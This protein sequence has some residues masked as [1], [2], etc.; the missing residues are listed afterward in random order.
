MAEAARFSLYSTGRQRN[1]Y[2]ETKV[3]GK[4]TDVTD[5]NFQADGQVALRQASFGSHPAQPKS[6]LGLRDSRNH[7][8]YLAIALH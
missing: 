4:L 1:H 5:S 8:G 3:T 7:N 6:E 2:Q